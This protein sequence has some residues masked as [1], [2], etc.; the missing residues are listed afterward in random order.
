LLDAQFSVHGAQFNV[1]SR[2]PGTIS[3]GGFSGQLKVIGQFSGIGE[4]FLAQLSIKPD[5]ALKC[6]EISH[7]RLLKDCIETVQL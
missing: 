1:H 6:R 4:A 3:L 5:K 2:G 7:N